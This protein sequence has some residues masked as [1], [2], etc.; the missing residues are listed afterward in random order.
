[1]QLIRPV[2][3]PLNVQL[4][5]FHYTVKEKNRKLKQKMPCEEICWILRDMRVQLQLSNAYRTHTYNGL[6]L[7]T[8][9]T[10]SMNQK[11][12]IRKTGIEVK[13]MSMNQCC[14]LMKYFINCVSRCRSTGSLKRTSAVDKPGSH[15]DMCVV[16]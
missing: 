14:K 3:I 7:N 6:T 1:M 16:T 8:L 5:S 10:A 15:H 2:E 9:L 11:R 13:K 4:I 12:Y